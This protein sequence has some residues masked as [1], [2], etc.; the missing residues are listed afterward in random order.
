MEGP[1]SRLIFPWDMY[2]GGKFFPLLYSETISLYIVFFSRGQVQYLETKSSISFNPFFFLR[3][4][5]SSLLLNEKRWNYGLVYL[6][7][8]HLKDPYTGLAIF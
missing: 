8:R 4:F 3:R 7:T 2:R 6:T 5:F 1:V